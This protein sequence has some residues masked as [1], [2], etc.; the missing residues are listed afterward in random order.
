M[1]PSMTVDQAYGLYL[2]AGV[3]LAA[4]RNVDRV[5]ALVLETFWRVRETDDCIAPGCVHSNRVFCQFDD[6]PFIG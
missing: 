2:N 3:S 1:R 5:A 6:E 4:F